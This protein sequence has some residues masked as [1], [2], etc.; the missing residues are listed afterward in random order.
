MKNIHDLLIYTQELSL[1]LVEDSP[2]LRQELSEQLALL[3]KSITT[4][5]NGEEGWE[6]FLE[7]PYD[8]VITDLEMPYMNGEELLKKIREHSPEQEVLIISA[9]NEPERLIS[10]INLHASGFIEK[11]LQHQSLLE[12]LFI[13]SKKCTDAKALHHYREQL[14]LDTIA[15]SRRINELE[16][17]FTAPTSCTDQYQNLQEISKVLEQEKHSIVTEWSS[18]P[19]VAKILH[20]H[21]ISADFFMKFFGY[22]TLEHLLS[23]LHLEQQAGNCPVLMALIDFFKQKNLHP[24]DIYMICSGLKSVIYHFILERY[25]YTRSVWDEMTKMMDRNFAGLLDTIIKYD[26]YEMRHPTTS[27]NE[28]PPH[29]HLQ[30]LSCELYTPAKMNEEALACR[31]YIIPQDLQELT[32]LEHEI[33]DMTIAIAFNRLEAHECVLTIGQY[34]NRYGSIL[35]AYPLLDYL[36]TQIIRLGHHFYQSADDVHQHPE[37]LHNVSILIET[38]VNDLVTWRKEVF[39]LCTQD[40]GYLNHSFTSNI[41]TIITF[42]QDEPEGDAMEEIEFF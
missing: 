9:Y 25:G 4:A 24:S 33:D 38:L 12:T 27:L 37:K 18:H 15:L 6:R 28:H 13:I 29:A 2:E 16:K 7:H 1:L 31:E 39:E 20:A 21:G 32:E 3:F 34:L 8:L 41:D 14:E 35:L 23:I 17:V 40:P 11:P 26:R 36:G 22:K 10:L 5:S 30:N 19:Q 42:M